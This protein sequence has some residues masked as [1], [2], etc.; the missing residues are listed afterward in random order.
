LKR[1]GYTS[2][3]YGIETLHPLA[4]KSIG[5][6]MHP[7]RIKQGLLDVRDYF[8][9]DNGRCTIGMGMIAGLPYESLDSM[10][11]SLDW[12]L[13][14]LK[15][16]VNIVVS[17]LHISKKEGFPPDFRG[18]Y[19]EWENTIHEQKY[20]TEASPANWNIDW[21]LV[22]DG[23]FKSVYKRFIENPNLAYM[24]ESSET[25]L[26]EAVKF[27]I[28]WLGNNDNFK[29]QSG[30]PWRI[31]EF[32]T[33]GEFTVDQF[34]QND[35]PGLAKLKGIDVDNDPDWKHK[36]T[37]VDKMQKTIS[38]YKYKKLSL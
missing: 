9:K 19:S 37:S 18:N 34:Y 30:D 7:D 25:N 31:S 1:I 11:S 20:Y 10:Q 38:E 23:H 13:D 29:H 16:D 32:V 5:K 35:L 24:W 15:G 33:S 27:A 12:L 3:F 28:G 14:N 26:W 8:K 2:H 21:D 6:G 36:I 4:G 17:P 22:Q